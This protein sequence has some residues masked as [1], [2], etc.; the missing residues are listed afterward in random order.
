MNVSY[1][2][3]G[4]LAVTMPAGTCQ[5]GQL[6]MVNTKGEAD[7]CSSNGPFCG[8]VEAVEDGWAAVQIAGFVTIPYT[9]MMSDPGYLMLASNGKGG[10]RENPD[11]K[12]YLG[13]VVDKTACT[14]TIK[15]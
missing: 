12:A 7:A 13:L 4:H 2:G 6:C 1:E 10:V 9:G 3:I 14:V 11:G 15:L 8:W 5:A